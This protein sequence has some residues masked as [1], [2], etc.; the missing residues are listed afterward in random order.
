MTYVISDIHGCYDEFKELLCKINFSDEDELF[1]LGDVVDRGTA[2][3]PLLKDIM[4]RPN[5]FLIKGNHEVMAQVVLNSLAVEITDESIN[6]LKTDALIYYF[7]WMNNGGEI[8]AA[9]FR[10]LSREE[11]KDILGYLDEAENYELLNIEGTRYILVHAGLGSFSP[12][13]DLPDYT[14]DQLVWDRADYDKNYFEDENIVLVTGHTP[15]P[16]IR[17]DRQPEVYKAN[18]HIAIDCGCVFGG[19]LAA[20]CLET[21]EITYVDAKKA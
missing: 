11:Q 5:V 1:I 20:I 3:I 9:Q 16:L 7:N 14:I 19:R 13:K 4:A 2:P 21:G 12:E 17:D 10:A 15:T 6:N 18:G 8:T